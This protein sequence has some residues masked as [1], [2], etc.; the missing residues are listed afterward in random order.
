MK[1]SSLLFCLFVLAGLFTSAQLPFQKASLSIAPALQKTFVRDGRIILRLSHQRPKDQRLSTETTLYL[2]PRD[3]NGTDALLL[4]PADP[5]LIIIGQERRNGST[6]GTLFYQAIYWQ[7]PDDCHENAPGNLYSTIDS[8]AF[9]TKDPL[10]VTLNKLFVAETVQEH[11]FVKTVELQSKILSDFSGHPRYLRASMLLPATYF[12]HPEKSYPICYRIPGINGK[13][14][15]ANNKLK[16]KEFMD[17][18]FSGKAPQ[19][20]YVFLDSRGPYGDTYQVDSENNGPCGKALTEEL[21]PAI[22]KMVHYRPATHR[23]YLAGLSTG[24]WVAMGLQIFY[25]DFFDGTWS[26]SPDPLEFEHYG[27]IN[28][29]KDESIFYNRFGYL[30]PGVRT[31]FGEPTRSMKDWITGENLGSRL[32]DYRT[33]GGQFG[34][35]NAV[36]G[37]RGKDGQP[38]LMFDPIT[39]KIDHEIA[40]QWEKYDLKKVLEKNWSTLGPKLQGKIWIWTGDMDDLYS[41]VATRFFEAFIAQTK[42][43]H[44]DAIIRFTPMAG[45]CEE[46]SDDDVIKMVAEKAAKKQ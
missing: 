7:N 17:W 41:N 9:P 1:K 29:Y 2:N 36:F 30:Q 38:T 20:I 8:V 31:K 3:W 42:N 19:V 11:K 14:T 25:P 45:H 16:D 24:G 10:R 37:P 21:I 15:F 39:G 34:A 4:D 18:W 26:Y 35:Y 5:R 44:S 27:L 46:F 40:K 43:P 33:S 12:D 23:R 13:Y 32:G 6:S 22:E 28:I